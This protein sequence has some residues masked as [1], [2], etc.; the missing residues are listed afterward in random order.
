MFEAIQ[1]EYVAGGRGSNTLGTALVDCSVCG[2]SAVLYLGLW[3]QDAAERRVQAHFI[4]AQH[5]A[6]Q[7]L[8]VRTWK[9]L[10][11]ESLHDFVA[12]GWYL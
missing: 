6:R 2:L 7:V 8:Q 5:K 11:A 10:C 3:T 4:Q 12:L 1:R 9:A